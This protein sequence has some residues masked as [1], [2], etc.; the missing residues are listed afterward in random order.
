MTSGAGHT[1][2]PRRRSLDEVG[3][4]AESSFS[5]AGEEAGK[6]RDLWEEGEGAVFFGGNEV[7]ESN[8]FENSIYTY[9][10]KSLT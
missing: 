4:G 10:Y 5:W 7:I 2:E 6:E 9:V 1:G 8:I 3:G